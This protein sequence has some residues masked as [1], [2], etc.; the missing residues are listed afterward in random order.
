MMQHCAVLL[1]TMNSCR[2]NLAPAGG[3][4]RAARPQA[5][6]QLAQAAVPVSGCGRHLVQGDLHWHT[7]WAGHHARGSGHAGMPTV[8]LRSSARRLHAA[9]QAGPGAGGAGALGGGGGLLQEGEWGVK[10]TVLSGTGMAWG[11]AS[12]T[13]LAPAILA[14]NKMPFCAACNT[15]PLMLAFALSILHRATRCPLRTARGAANSRP[16]WM[17]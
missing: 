4:R 6:A 13:L 15:A 5:A 16:C 7:D 10:L 3:G 1:L 8:P 14:C 2:L 12:S 11:D 9:V 17:R